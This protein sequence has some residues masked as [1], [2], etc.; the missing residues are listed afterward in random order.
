MPSLS[1]CNVIVHKSCKECAPVCTKVTSYTTL[2]LLE[3]ICFPRGLKTSL[4]KNRK[5]TQSAKIQC[6]YTKVCK[7]VKISSVSKQSKHCAWTTLFRIGS[8]KS[9]KWHFCF[10]R[11]ASSNCGVTGRMQKGLKRKASQNPCVARFCVGGSLQGEHVSVQTL[12]RKQA[13]NKPRINQVSFCYFGYSCHI[14]ILH[15]FLDNFRALGQ[16]K[17]QF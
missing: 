4:R 14:I 13:L 12:Q 6:L 17:W 8:K 11:V 7:G 15:K 3:H 5:C 1:D 16:L 2:F 10:W 9:L